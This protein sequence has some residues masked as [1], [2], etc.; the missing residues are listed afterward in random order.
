MKGQILELRTADGSPPCGADPRL[1]ARLPRPAQRLRPPDRRRHG[2]GAGLRHHGHRG[3]RPRAAARGLP[4]APGC[5]RDGAVR[6]DRGMRPGT[7]DNLP[8]VGPGGL[9]GLV[10]GDRPLPQ[11]HPAGAA[12]AEGGR[13]LAADPPS[14]L[15]RMADKTR[16]R[17]GGGAMRVELNGEAGGAAGR[18][19]P[20]RRG[21]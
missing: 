3:R 6:G 11:R 5:R 15:R 19:E 17:R 20:R 18:R 8:C 10:L 2:R 9:E 1:R 7:P 16:T 21:P 13:A 12:A 4:A 14:R